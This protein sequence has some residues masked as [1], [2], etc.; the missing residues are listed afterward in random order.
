[1]TG[2]KP[3]VRA[4]IEREMKTISKDASLKIIRA[5]FEFDPVPA[6]Q[7]YPGPKLVLFTSSGDTPNDL[8]NLVPSVPHRRIES[9]SHWMQM[10][11]PEEFNQMLDAF[12]AA[13]R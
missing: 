10:D 12:L 3:D 6:L 13:N 4:Q 9:T 7:R 8:Q 5:A 11:A 1:L 2:A